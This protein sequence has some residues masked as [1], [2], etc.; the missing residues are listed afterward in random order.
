MKVY[1]IILNHKGWKDTVECLESVLKSTYKNFQLLLVDNSPTNEDVEKIIE[2]CNGAITQ[3]Q[4]I[5]NS[6]VYPLEIKPIAYRYLTEEELLNGKFKEQ[7]LIIKAENK[8]ITKLREVAKKLD[9][10]REEKEKN[11]SELENK[12]ESEGKVVSRKE[13]KKISKKISSIDKIISFLSASFATLN[14]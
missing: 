7:L 3:I 1:I 14:T 13:I 2:W 11:M 4:T 6:I 8:N 5:C 12:T 9:T 10:Q